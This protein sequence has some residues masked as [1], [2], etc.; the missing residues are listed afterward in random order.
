MVSMSLSF[1]SL[2]ILASISSATVLAPR[3]TAINGFTYASCQS[4]YDFLSP[5]PQFTQV[6]NSTKMTVE[7]CTSECEDDYDYAAIYG[8]VCFCGSTF[9]DYAPSSQDVECNT[10]CP[11]NANEI[12]GGFVN[13]A[14]GSEW[15]S[16]WTT[17]E[18]EV[19]VNPATISSS[20]IAS[21]Q[22]ASTKTVSLST[23]AASLTTSIIY[24]TE[25]FT[26]T[27]CAASVTNCPARVTASLVS[28]STTVYPVVPTTSKASILTVLSASAASTVKPTTALTNATTSAIKTTSVAALGNST[29][30]ATGVVSS[31][32]TIV[33]FKSAAACESVKGFVLLLTFVGFLA[34]L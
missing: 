4:A 3:A 24:A 6:D 28:V 19:P 9:G 2:A 15:Y 20:T 32:P 21:T 29:V 17:E 23:V 10:P 1:A 12:C 5:N 18:E 26:I 34:F 27:S 22:S 25:T 7:L 14:R 16:L 31:T 11:G 8:T 13:V 30:K 33:P